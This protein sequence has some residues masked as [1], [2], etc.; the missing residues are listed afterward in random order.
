[1]Y[2]LWCIP[3]FLQLEI[4]FTNHIYTNLSIF[5]LSCYYV[6]GMMICFIKTS[7]LFEIN[8]L[9]I[10]QKLRTCFSI[11]LSQQGMWL[12]Y[13][14]PYVG[15]INPFVTAIDSKNLVLIEK[16]RRKITFSMND[17]RWCKFEDNI[18]QINQEHC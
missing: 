17:K 8:S 14:S 3:K 1:M 2:Y 12:I 15:S 5:P 4:W 9:L 7:L 6:F 16:K 11:T 10:S 18:H 13:F